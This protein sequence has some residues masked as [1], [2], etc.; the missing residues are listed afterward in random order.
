MTD[1]VVLIERAG[2]VNWTNSTPARAGIL[3]YDDEGVYMG[4][5]NF[6]QELTDFGGEINYINEDTIKG[7][8][9]EYD[10]ETLHTFPELTW[11]D[12]FNCDVVLSDNIAMFLVRVKGDMTEYIK[13]FKLK[14]NITRVVELTD[15]KYIKREDLDDY[16]I[17][18]RIR[19]LVKYAVENYDWK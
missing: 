9:R 17:Y 16:C 15:I 4:I 1:Q 7:S 5:D 11:S 3:L 10:E 18:K 13:K 8:I 19:P 6:T 12:I 2:K 14:K